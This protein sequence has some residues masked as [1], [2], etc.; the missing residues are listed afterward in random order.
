MVFDYKQSE[1]VLY[2][3]FDFQSMVSMWNDE[4]V[5]GSY[6]RLIIVSQSRNLC[7]MDSSMRKL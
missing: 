2:C 6:G 1:G 4:V 3:Y 5:G 7:I